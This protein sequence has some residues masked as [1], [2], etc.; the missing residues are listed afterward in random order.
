MKKRTV[1]LMVLMLISFVVFTGCGK[2]PGVTDKLGNK[3]LK[4][5]VE[6]QVEEKEKENE[7]ENEKLVREDELSPTPKEKREKHQVVLYFADKDVMNTYRIKKEIV[8]SK[9]GQLPK[10]ALEAW[11]KG[12]QHKELTGLVPSNVVI[13]YVENIN[14]VANVSF[15]KDI[16]QINLGSSGELMFAEQLAM[17]M[18]QFGFDK[19]Q[20]LVGGKVGEFLLGHLYTGEPFEAKN[21]ED[22][23]WVSEKKSRE[24]VLQNTA[25]RIYEPTPNTSVKDQIIVK[26][27]ARVFEATFLYEFEDGHNLLDGGV[28]MTSAGAPEWGEFEIVIKFDPKKVTNNSGTI[29]LYEASPKD[30]SRT[31]ELKI[32]VKI[33]K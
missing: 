29:I 11:I 7:N 4:N 2:G 18:E 23:Q 21:P 9:K 30:G 14:G 6:N 17:I 22:Y 24:F 16:S 32:P 5:P 19:T 33:T 27:V 28:T 12:P 3:E 13:E 8:V 25:F 1:F 10:A 15:S 31:N 26:G 20:I